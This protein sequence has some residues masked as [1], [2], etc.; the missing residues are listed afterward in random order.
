MNF[1]ETSN[2]QN[3]GVNQT[4]S[5]IG[6]LRNLLFKI[7]II[8]DISTHESKTCYHVL[9]VVLIVVHAEML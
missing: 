1:S 9:S 6:Q 4:R 5:S 7:G 3:N 8:F 2:T